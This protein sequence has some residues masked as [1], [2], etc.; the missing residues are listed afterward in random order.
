MLAAVVHSQLWMAIHP[1][2]AEAALGGTQGT[3]EPAAS[4]WFDG[5]SLALAIGAVALV[6]L[7]AMLVSTLLSSRQARQLNSPR[8]LLGQLCQAH[9]LVKRQERLLLKAARVLAVQHPA[10]F[11]LEPALVREATKHPALASRRAEL[12][13]LSADLF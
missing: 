6:L 1:L 3:I 8:R 12:E 4:P 2:L 13:Q 10:R 5:P 7:A 11:F 9:G